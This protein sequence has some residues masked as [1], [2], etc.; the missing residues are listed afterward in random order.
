MK[1]K[2]LKKSSGKSKDEKKKYKKVLSFF[3]TFQD[4]NKDSVDPEDEDNEDAPVKEVS[5]LQREYDD[6]V[7]LRDEFI[8]S[9]FEFYLGIRDKD[10]LD[11][12]EESEEKEGQYKVL[13][14]IDITKPKNNKV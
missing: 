8:P 14:E 4:F 10:D 7:F 3:N 1:L 6:T 9:A 2:V 11:E 13:Q 5:E 12:Y